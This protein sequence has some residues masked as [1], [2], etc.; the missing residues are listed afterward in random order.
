VPDDIAPFYTGGRYIPAPQPAGF[1]GSF[2]VNTYAL[3]SRPLYTLPALALHEAVPGHHLQIALA[4]EREDQPPFRRFGYVDAYGEAG[5]SMRSISATRWA[6]TGRPRTVRPPDLRDVARLSTRGRHRAARD[7]LVARGR[8]RLH[9]RAHR[10]ERAR[11]GDGG[12]SL[13]QLAGQALAYKL[14]ELQ[15]RDLRARGEARLGNRFD[16]PAFHDAVL[17]QGSVPLTVLE[18]EIDRGSRGGSTA[19]GGE[20]RL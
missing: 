19:E 5:R 4:A 11:G 12:R 3:Q 13:H 17:A 10:A 9:A 1:A 14:G 7:A 18:S 2:W 8:A 15:I 6:S 20:R 16:L